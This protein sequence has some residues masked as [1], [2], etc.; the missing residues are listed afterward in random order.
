MADIHKHDRD[1]LDDFDFEPCQ[2]INHIEEEPLGTKAAAYAGTV[3]NAPGCSTMVVNGLSQQLIHEVNAINPGI[4]VSF[5]ELNVQLGNAA[6]AFLQPQAKEALARAIADRQNKTLSINSGYR[7]IVQQ[8]LLYGWRNGRKGCPY[9]LV[10]PPGRSNHQGGLAIDINDHLGW[11]PYLEKYGWRWFGDR[12]KPHFTYRGTGTQDIRNNAVKAFQRL[13]NKNNPD[14]KIAEDGVYGNITLARIN[15]TSVKGFKIAPWDEVPRILR[16][17]R[18]ITEGSDVIRLQQALADK[19]WEIFPDGL[20]GERT[21]AIVK[22]FQ[23]Q[24]DIKIDGIVGSDTR[25]ALLA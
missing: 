21:A 17:S 22:E 23:K 1:W 25:D 20:F 10:A 12:D 24:A 6:Y 11:K 19:G 13:W 15:Q 8:L 5:D 16:F 4:L 3:Q 7:T 2:E 18:P 9:G 14:D